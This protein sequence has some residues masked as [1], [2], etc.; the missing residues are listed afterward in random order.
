[1]AFRLRFRSRRDD[2]IGD[3]RW[4]ETTQPAHALDLADLIGDALFE[5]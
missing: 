3:L 2:Q 5:L 1:M 4:Q